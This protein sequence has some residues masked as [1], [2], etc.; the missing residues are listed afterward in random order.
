MLHKILNTLFSTLCFLFATVAFDAVILV[1]RSNAE[2]NLCNKTSSDVSVSIAYTND[3][4]QNI[5][6]GWW[7][8]PEN[9]CEIVITGELKQENFFVYAVNEKGEQWQ[10]DKNLCTD[11]IAFTISEQKSCDNDGY[12]E[13]G[14]MTVK[15]YPEKESMIVNLVDQ[16]SD[17]SIGGQ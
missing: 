8:I 1:S 17:Q 12:F 14:F 13:T 10:G 5:S 11:R 4:N 3:K 16:K 9:S 2:V 15:N 7:T 6:E